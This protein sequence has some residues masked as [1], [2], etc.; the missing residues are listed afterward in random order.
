MGSKKVREQLQGRGNM[1]V[2]H[3]CLRE[4]TCELAALC[5]TGDATGIYGWVV[6]DRGALPQRMP[7]VAASRMKRSLYRLHISDD[8]HN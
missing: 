4:R 5:A 6:S 2:M 7:M 3:S 8:A 1:L